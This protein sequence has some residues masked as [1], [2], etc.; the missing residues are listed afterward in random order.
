[1]RD[2]G[3]VA[4]QRSEGSARSTPINVHF[5]SSLKILPDVL[6]SGF[7]NREQPRQQLRSSKQLPGSTDC[8]GVFQQ[9]HHLGSDQ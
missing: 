2:D 4:L 8:A 9:T 6:L 7:R 1:M 5:K 3:I